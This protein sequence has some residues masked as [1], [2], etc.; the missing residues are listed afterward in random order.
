MND[1]NKTHTQ[2]C[3]N[4]VNIIHKCFPL[5]EKF[6]RQKTLNNKWLSK[7]LLK[8]I[9]LKNRLFAKKL[10]FPI[11]KNIDDYHLQLK[12]VEKNKK[13]EKRTYFKEQLETAASP[14]KFFLKLFTCRIFSVSVCMR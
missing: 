3:E 4:L 14:P 6:I 2:F 11:Q 7:S 10:K 1:V 12:I 8:E 9:K 5:K 13:I